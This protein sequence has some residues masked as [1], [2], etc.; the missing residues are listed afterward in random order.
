MHVRK[1]S[2]GSG[3]IGGG[4]LY[5]EVLNAWPWVLAR[6]LLGVCGRWSASFECQRHCCQREL[7]SQPGRAQT[8]ARRLGPRARRAGAQNHDTGSTLNHWPFPW[9]HLHEGYAYILTHPGTPTIFYDH[10]FAD[11]LGDAIRELVRIRERNGLHCRSKAR[12]R[13]ARRRALAPRLCEEVRAAR[14]AVLPR[15]AAQ[16]ADP[17]V[18]QLAQVLVVCTVRPWQWSLVSTTACVA[19]LTND[20]IHCRP[21]TPPCLHGLP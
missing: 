10:F 5:H 20:H 19:V 4:L 16:G 2:G 1:A 7:P 14:P 15:H 3:A 8:A 6:V 17:T 9:N 13:P 18:L 12:R 11:G 21:S